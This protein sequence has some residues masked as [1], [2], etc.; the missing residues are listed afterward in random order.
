[1][2]RINL[3]K[4]IM[5]EPKY[6]N[7]KKY[8]EKILLEKEKKCD[9]EG[10]IEK[11]N[12]INEIKFYKFYEQNFSGS[13]LIKVNFNVDIINISNDEIIECTIIKID[14][15]SIVAEGIHP[16]LIILNDDY[17]NLS[18]LEEGDIIEVRITNWDISIDKN[19]IK[20]VGKFVKKIELKKDNGK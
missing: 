6:L 5:I 8:I 13:I 19:I 4:T 10:Y 3:E 14:E 7:D 2:K 16:I 20:G 15:D 9:R 11:I 18:Y 12:K 1:M 17:E